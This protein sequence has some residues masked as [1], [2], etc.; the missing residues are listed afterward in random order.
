LTKAETKQ[1]TERNRI[2]AYRLRLKSD[3]SLKEKAE[4]LK[5]KKKN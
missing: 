5:A 4:S 2:R 3:P 1:V